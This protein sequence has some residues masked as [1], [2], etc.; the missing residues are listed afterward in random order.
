M[1]PTSILRIQFEIAGS[2]S[3]ARWQ[4]FP[5]GSPGLR[6]ICA[7][8]TRRSRFLGKKRRGVSFNEVFLGIFGEC[9]FFSQK[10]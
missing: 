3:R 8:V 2:G 9:S 7:F 10:I 1:K 4:P 6:D 5:P